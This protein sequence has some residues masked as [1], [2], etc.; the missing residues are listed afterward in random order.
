M[1]ATDETVEKIWS[2]A[3]SVTS[4]VT[5][6]TEYYVQYQPKVSTEVFSTL[7]YFLAL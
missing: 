6:Y 3:V 2:I 7:I 1:V 4:A 5:Q